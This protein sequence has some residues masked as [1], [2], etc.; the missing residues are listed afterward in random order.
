M[1]DPAKVWV[2]VTWDEGMPLV[3]SYEDEHEAIEALKDA[4]PLG[5]RASLYAYDETGQSTRVEGW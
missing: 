4:R 1:S 5:P 2:L 3:R